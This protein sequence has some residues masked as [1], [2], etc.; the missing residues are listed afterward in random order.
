MFEYLN[1]ET[2]EIYHFPKA[3]FSTKE[4]CE[5]WLLENG[6]HPMEVWEYLGD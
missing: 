5:E 2:L 3:K 6:D 4:A 1:K